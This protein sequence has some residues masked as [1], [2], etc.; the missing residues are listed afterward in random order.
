MTSSEQ[1]GEAPPRSE[2]E[3]PRSSQATIH[4]SEAAASVSATSSPIPVAIGLIERNGAYLIRRRPE[5]PGSPMPGYW[6]FP[7]G[8]CL[9][10]ESPVDC[11]RRECLEEVGQPVVVRSLRRVVRHTYP[12]GHVEMHFFD[13]TL[14]TPGAEPSSTT[15][16]LWV[17]GQDLPSYTFPG[18]NKA[19]VADLVREAWSSAGGNAAM[20]EDA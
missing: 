14:E 13:C 7:G 15:G 2:D 18:A 9:P 19:L 17:R 8:K 5:Q 3:A 11:A 10:G 6:E 12:H 20:A 4:G 16:F 1:T